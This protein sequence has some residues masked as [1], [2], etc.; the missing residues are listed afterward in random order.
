MIAS[1]FVSIMTLMEV[2]GEEEVVVVVV[3]V[4]VVVVVVVV[5]VI[6]L[7][8]FVTNGTSSI[9]SYNM[10]KIVR[11]TYNSIISLQRCQ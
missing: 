6:V 1:L 9:Y 8:V 5:I 10:L 7:V 3:I 11:L 2:V 4:L